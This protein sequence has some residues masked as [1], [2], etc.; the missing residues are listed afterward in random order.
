MLLQQLFK[1]GAV[2]PQRAVNVIG[3]CVFRLHSPSPALLQTLRCGQ[4]A[5]LQLS[6][7]S[8]C[9]QLLK[10]SHVTD[11]IGQQLDM[12]RLSERGMSKAKS[13]LKVDLWKETAKL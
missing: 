6:P 13:N 10:E 3:K 7:A 11:F 1:R 5:A 4:L 2:T 9:T 12:V 8:L